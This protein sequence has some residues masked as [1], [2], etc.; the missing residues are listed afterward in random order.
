MQH[1]F[2][3]LAPEYAHRW[4]TMKVTRPQDALAAARRMLRHRADYDAVQAAC[5]VPA[6]VVAGL[7]ERESSSDFSTYL[8]NG[9][10]LD[11]PTI[12]VPKNRGPFASWALGAADALHLDGLDAVKVWNIPRACYEPELYNGFG[13]RNRGFVTGYVWA[14]T[15]QY[16]GGKYVA[17]GVWDPSAIDQQLG[18]A[19]LMW[20][21][22]QISPS[23]GAIL[24]DAAPPIAP[25]HVLPLPVPV[26]LQDAAWIQAAL[27]ELGADPQL[28]V[29][30]SYGRM[31]RAAVAVFQRAH[32]LT[33]DGLAGPKTIPEIE[34]ARAALAL[35]ATL[36]AAAA[37]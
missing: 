24:A 21:M 5:G 7:N 33:P 1:P 9:D 8:G 28:V 6:V 14:G 26:G 35:L 16:T 25:P 3:V 37:A 11:K 30:G 12:H 4:A 36:P 20:A 17:D 34:A 29:D 23:L 22:L 15:D 13:P 27:N 2:E 32:G 10:P 31:T 19:A 18:T